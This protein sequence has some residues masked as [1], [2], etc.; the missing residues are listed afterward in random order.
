MK[1]FEAL[2]LNEN[3]YIH[4]SVPMS[5]TAYIINESF[6]FGQKM[7]GKKLSFNNNMMREK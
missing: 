1:Q 7:G 6:C 3:R 2:L 4:N 5:I